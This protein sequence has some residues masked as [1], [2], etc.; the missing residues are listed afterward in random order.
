M[1]QRAF[2]RQAVGVLAVLLSIT[3]LSFSLIEL[4]PGDP[5]E[6][7]LRASGVIPSESA[8]EA[9]RQEMG[10]N[11]PL[12]TRYAQWLGGVLT[13]DFG[14]S[15]STGLNVTATLLPAL[16]RTAAL[17]ACA[18]ALSVLIALPVGLI[19]SRFRDRPADRAIRFVTYLFGAT[20]SFVL[21]VGVLY[22]F[23]VRLRFFPSIS[24]LSP[25]G[26]VMP[27]AVLTL[28]TA[29]WMIRLVRTAALE[30]RSDVYLM[31]L[32]AR[33]VPPVRI[34]LY[35]LKSAM[36]PILASLG[37]CL[38]SMLAGAVIVENIF[39]LSGLGKL[40]MSAI[41][42]RDFPL[43]QG[44]I[45]WVAVIYYLINFSCDRLYAFFE[46]RME[47]EKGR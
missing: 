19:C 5:A 30:N 43:L 24:N 23:G 6:I 16:G 37:T 31:A 7:M 26:L 15:Y 42:A 41:Q 11:Q 45:L 29:V 22:L 8:V 13:G 32:K 18:F 17:T 10:L 38:G 47:K 25:R 1:R 27:A 44:F 35:I 28:G 46:P 12:L 36:L 21:G 20:P 39:S 9:L 34:E 33:G 3:F 40:A 2:L 14:T 4:A